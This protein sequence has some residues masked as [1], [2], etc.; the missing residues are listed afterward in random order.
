MVAIFAVLEDEVDCADSLFLIR[1]FF[2]ELKFHRR[3]LI[4]FGNILKIHRLLLGS[5]FMIDKADLFAFLCCDQD[6]PVAAMQLSLASALTTA[7]N[8]LKY[9]ELA[10][11]HSLRR[12]S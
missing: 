6:H 11:W 12:E 10:T 3:R 1:G 7:I 5:E 2:A 8:L 4:G 9:H